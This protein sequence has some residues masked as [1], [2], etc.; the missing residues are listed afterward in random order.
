MPR[1]KATASSYDPSRQRGRAM[2]EVGPVWSRLRSPGAAVGQGK[3]TRRSPSVGIEGRGVSW[4]GGTALLGCRCQVPRD[5]PASGES[6]PNSKVLTG[7]QLKPGLQ[8]VVPGG[9]GGLA[10]D[11]GE[12]L[13]CDAG[14]GRLLPRAMRPRCLAPL[15]FRA[16]TTRNV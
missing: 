12:C 10:V 9:V 7:L 13:Q 11:L 14:F 3:S 16:V 15:A 4:G 5:G 1:G 8:H 6:Q 2:L